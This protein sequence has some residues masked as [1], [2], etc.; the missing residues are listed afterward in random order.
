MKKVK[1]VSGFSAKMALAAVVMAGFSL[2]G[3]EKEDFNV[4][5]PNIDVTVPDVTFPEAENG[6]VYVMF[7]ASSTDGNLLNGVKYTNASGEEVGESVTV[8]GG[9]GNVTLTIS[10][11]K[12]GYITE[13]KTIEVA[14]PVKGTMMTL[15]VNFVLTTVEA[16]DVPVEVV[17]VP[18]QVETK[19]LS[20]AMETPEGGFQ[21]NVEYT[22]TVQVPTAAPYLTVEQKNA[23]NAAIDA[24]GTTET[25]ASAEDLVV[26]KSLLR[27]KV[28]AFGTSPKTESQV[29]KF[30]L[31]AAASSVTVVV[32]FDTYSQAITLSTTYNGT[33]YSVD[34]SYTFCGN[35][36]ITGQA[37]GIE[38]GHDHGHGHGDDSTA[39]GGTAG[40]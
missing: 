35:S 38:I 25:R 37:D 29:Y 19:T 10:A 30:V 26:V 9:N 22:A 16:E 3:C 21:P 36:M 2:T 34:G 11:S 13:T 32:T 7:T 12:D 33:T 6:I 17:G 28:A 8:V 15:P 1:F 5:V 20:T 23:F 18:V 31:S 27:G 24:L 14:E 39:G 4:N 40:K